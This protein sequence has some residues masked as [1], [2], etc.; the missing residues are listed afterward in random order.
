[1]AAPKIGRAALEREE[2][3][4]AEEVANLVQTEQAL[5]Q[6]LTDVRAMREREVGALLV[7]R[8]ILGYPAEG[9]S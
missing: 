9:K 6:R 5:E 3:E 1:M 7:L 8:K 4:K 2:K